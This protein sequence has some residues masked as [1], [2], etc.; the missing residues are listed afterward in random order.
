MKSKYKYLASAAFSG[1]FG[2]LVAFSA[3]AQ[4]RGGGGGGSHGGGGGGFHGG[5]GGGSHFGGG[6]SGGFSR[7][8]GG[9]FNRGGGGSFNRGGVSQGRQSA[10]NALHAAPSQAYRGGNFRGNVGGHYNVPSRGYSNGYRGGVYGGRSY[11]GRGAYNRGF[12]GR[13]GY[14]YRGGYNRFYGRY[15]FYNRYYRPRL[16]FSLS[17]LPFGYYPFYWGDMQYYYSDGYYY[18]YNKNK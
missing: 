2:L 11:N 5:G 14:G 10:P 9:S 12:Y 17:V 18:N 6:S 3:N 7:G 13:G 15:A 1:L 4:H 16:G 8:G